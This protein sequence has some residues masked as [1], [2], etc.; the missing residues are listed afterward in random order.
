MV[1]SARSDHLGYRNDR[2]NPTMDPTALAKM[3]TNV[4]V[5]VIK[6]RIV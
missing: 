3:A 1:S 6:E 4:Q 5:R 2:G